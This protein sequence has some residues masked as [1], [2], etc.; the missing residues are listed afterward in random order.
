[1]SD[2]A[3]LRDDFGKFSQAIGRPLARWQADALTLDAAITVA[4]APRQSGKSRSLAN[5]A[6]WVAFRRRQQRVLVVSASD[7]AARRLLADIRAVAAGSKL[8]AGSLVVE[9]AQLVTLTNGSEIRCVPASERQIRGWSVDLLLVDEA[10]LV[11]DEILLGA[12][13][14]TT[15]ARPEA[16][17]VMASSASQASGAFYDHVKLGDTG[18]RHVRTVRWALQDC[19]WIT[20]TQ[21]EVMKGSM[22]ETRFNAEM[23]GIYPEGFESL[24]SRAILEAATADYATVTLTDLTGPARVLGGVDWGATNDRSACV[25]IGRLPI[26]SDKPVFAVVMAQRWA[27]GYPLTDVIGEL[28]ACRAHWAYLTLERNGLGEPCCQMLAR[29]LRERPDEEGGAP[30]RAWSI[31]DDSGYIPTPP[32]PSGWQQKNPAWRSALNAVHVSADTK[33][34]T[35]SALRLLIDGGQLVLPASATE[36]LR[37]LMLLRVDLAPSGTERIEASSGHDDVADALALAM[38]PHRDTSKRWRTVLGDLADPRRPARAPSLPDTPLRTVQT[39]SGLAVPA[40]SVFQSVNGRDI[41]APADVLGREHQ[42]VR[43]GDFILNTH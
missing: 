35:Y 42:P 25:A 5:L 3:V 10:A 18:I 15:A 12:A 34:A 36:L 17:I 9:Q 27:A 26:D 38:G 21:I 29:R 32:P 1:M 28:A 13:F 6:L 11:S 33:A 40:Q 19:D 16:R 37:E 43:V 2:V 23:L 7:D 41:S 14:P 30:P 39:G 4:L 8:L 20:P 24:F 31:I 22:S